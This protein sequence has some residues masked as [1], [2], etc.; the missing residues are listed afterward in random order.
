MFKKQ[1]DLMINQLKNKSTID[2]L[3]D[4]EL[5]NILN[6][7]MEDFRHRCEYYQQMQDC[8]PNKLDAG[9]ENTYLAC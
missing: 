6:K 4:N 7:S 9:I 8:F 2:S 3:K 5:V 1:Q